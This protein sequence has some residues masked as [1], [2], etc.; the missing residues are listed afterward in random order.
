MAICDY[1]GREVALPFKCP[2]CG[3]KFCIEHHLPENHEC[4]GLKVFKERLREQGV[5]FTMPYYSREIPVTT[6]RP[7]KSF[8]RRFLDRRPRR[9]HYYYGY[10][11]TLSIQDKIRGIVITSLYFMLLLSSIYLLMLLRFT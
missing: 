9:K 7:R 3:G 1:C 6:S 10:Q 4:P 2:Y 5:M 8:L 11:T